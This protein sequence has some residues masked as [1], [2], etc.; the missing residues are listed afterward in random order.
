MKAAERGARTGAAARRALAAVALVTVTGLGACGG[1]GTGP[2]VEVVPPE[3]VGR[4]VAEPACLPQ[5]GFTLSSV[6]NPADSV[7][8]T[9]FTGISTEITMTREGTFRL[10]TRPGPDTASTATVRVIPGALV[11]TDR[12]GTVDTL[13]YQLAGEYLRLQFRRTFTVFDFTGDGANDP[14]NARG[15]FRRR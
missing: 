10:Q 12:L 11:V 8:V 13:D 6:A 15:S 3:L 5:C 14:A 7:N 1:D 2:G 4:W 9:A